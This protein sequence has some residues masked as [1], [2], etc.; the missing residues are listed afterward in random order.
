MTLSGSSNLTGAGWRSNVEQFEELVHSDP[1]SGADSQRERF[2]AVWDHGSPLDLLRRNGDWDLYRQ[3]ARDRRR[4]ERQDRRRLLKLQAR[5]G[6]LIGNL[7]ARSTREAPGFIGITNDQWWAFQLRQRDGADR[8]LFW[9]RNTKQFRALATGGVLFHL[10]KDPDAPEEQR[11][12]RGWSVYPG[13]YEV[14]DAG[15]AFARY[16]DLL[17]VTT[18]GQLHARLEISPGASIGIIHLESMS[19]LERAVTLAELRANGVS[20]ASNIVAG[21][22]IDLAEVATIFELGGLGIPASLGLAADERSGYD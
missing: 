22:K 21:R 15:D 6:Q 9:R 3:R 4:L 10:V 17:G 5:T 13:D 18:L 2:E 19:E 7:S 8:Y 16:G 14:A 1:S 12:I 11:A 20:F